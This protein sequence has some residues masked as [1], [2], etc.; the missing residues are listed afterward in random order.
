METIQTNWAELTS[1]VRRFVGRRL[2][3][4]HAADDVTQDVMLKVQAQLGELPPEEKLSAWVWRVARNAI[5]DHYRAR[6][7]RDHGSID[8]AQVPDGT[9]ADEQHE[10]VRELTPCLNKLIAHLPEPYRQAL[11]LA[12]LEGLSQQE[13]AERAGVSLSGAK[14][15]VQRARQQLRE[16]ILD[17]CDV[18]PDGRGG[19]ADVQTTERTGRYCDVDDLGRGCGG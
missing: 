9:G 5:V 2:S 17:C 12:D 1:Q 3:D 10:A 8:E 13:L 7:V 16:L 6:G 19:V 4:P 14:S 11:T 18:V 15:R